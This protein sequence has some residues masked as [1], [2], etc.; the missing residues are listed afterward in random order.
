[1]TKEWDVE[2]YQQRREVSETEH[3]MNK[4]T[5]IAAERDEAIAL[6]RRAWPVIG[7]WSID[8]SVPA[9]VRAFLD[10]FDAAD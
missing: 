6:L 2:G 4:V 7:S 10:R 3:Y 8:E 5:A 9:D 1:M